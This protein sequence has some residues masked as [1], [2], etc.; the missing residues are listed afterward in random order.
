M[1][2]SIPFIRSKPI[3]TVLRWQV[4]ATAAI[5]AI[6]AAVS[7]RHGALS[8]ILGGG[9][10]L[11]AGVAY[12]LVVSVSRTGSAAEIVRTMFR[13]EALKIALIIVQLGLILTTYKSMVA[14]AFFSA[15]IATALAFAGAISV[16]ED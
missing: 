2:P 16:R 6:A 1:K 9:V 4:I 15:F 3:R 12:A 5:A 8:A 13:A 11:T 10:N 7:G 14:I